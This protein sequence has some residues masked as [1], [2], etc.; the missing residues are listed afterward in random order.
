MQLLANSRRGKCQSRKPK[1]SISSHS[2]GSRAAGY[3]SP[4]ANL[5]LKESLHLAPVEKTKGLM[6][7][8]TVRPKGTGSEGGGA[9]Y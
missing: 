2:G 5:T 8:G 6:G 9:G 4:H 7:T 1:L 3:V